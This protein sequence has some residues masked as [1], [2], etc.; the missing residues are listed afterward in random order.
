M[1]DEQLANKEH[2]LTATGKM[3]DLKLFNWN[4]GKAK[5]QCERLI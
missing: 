2:V 4:S 5:M 3:K 1:Y